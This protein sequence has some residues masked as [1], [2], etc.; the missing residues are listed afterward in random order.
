MW[1][2]AALRLYGEM[3][4]SLDIANNSGNLKVR[5]QIQANWAQFIWLKHLVP[6][7][8]SWGIWDIFLKLPDMTQTCRRPMVILE[9]HL[10]TGRILQIEM[11]WGHR[12]AYLWFCGHLCLCI[13]MYELNPTLCTQWSLCGKSASLWRLW[14]PCSHADLSD[15]GWYVSTR[16]VHKDS[17]GPQKPWVHQ[18][19]HL[20]WIW[21]IPDWFEL[22]F[23]C[24]WETCAGKTVRRDD[25]VLP[26]T[27]P[28][29]L[30]HDFA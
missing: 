17:G 16:L 5:P 8:M 23:I 11:P 3:N 26:A 21:H 28:G 30:G 12:Y 27:W 1:Y 15:Y 29:E 20:L 2:K 14:M 4:P 13:S 19:A 9:Q 22:L 7:D 25:V 24:A 6:F 18:S 10:R